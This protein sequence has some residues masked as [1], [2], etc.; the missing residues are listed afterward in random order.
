MQQLLRRRDA[1]SSLFRFLLLLA[2]A[3]SSPA[4]FA[5]NYTQ[6]FDTSPAPGWTVVSG[7]WAVSAGTANSTAD[8]AADIAVYG[9][10][11]WATDF[12]YH[13]EIDNQYANWGNLAGAV[14]NYQDANNYYAVL[15]APVGQLLSPP[16]AYLQRVINGAATTVAQASYGGG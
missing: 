5:A 6:T 13:V 8:G 10:G 9:G 7:T 3:V 16:Q 12:V 11:A 1:L 2:V 14:F 4:S 15:F